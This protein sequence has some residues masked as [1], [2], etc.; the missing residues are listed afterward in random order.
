MVQIVDIHEPLKLEDYESYAFLSQA[1]HELREEAR[2]TAPLLKG[3]TVWMVNSTAQGGG[4]AEMLPKMISMLRELG[5]DVRWEV[6]GSQRPEFFVLTKRLHNLIHGAGDPE[7]SSDDRDL[8]EAV[9]RTNAQQ[10]E[11]LV[12]P[13]DL[14]VIHDPQPLGAGALV[15]EAVG[16]PAI[17]RCHIGLDD[18]TRETCAAWKFLEPWALKFDH[19]VFSAPEYIPDFLTGNAHV[20]H[21][22]ID[23]LSHKNRELSPHK[24]QGILCNS[25]LAIE[26]EPVLTPPFEFPARRLSPS[27]EWLP[28]VQAAALGLLYRP[29]IVQISRWDRLKGYGPLLEGFVRL[30]AF[31]E[32]S[33]LSDLHRRRLQILRLIL[34]GPDP[35]SVA[36]DPEGRQVIEEL[37]RQVLALPE[38][39]Q[40]DVALISLPMESRKE[41]ALMVN[42][43]QRCA[44]IVAQ[45]SIQEGFGL[46]VT[47]AMWKRT[48][49]LGSSACGIRQQIRDGIDGRLVRDPEDPEEIARALDEMLEDRMAR[50]HYASNAQRRVHAQFLIFSQLREWLRLFAGIVQRE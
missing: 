5:V 13:Q 6:I 41:N 43:L 33:D 30:K 17:W 44:T 45:N 4:V 16:L 20:I 34:G 15:K 27:G 12:E 46:T 18:R 50:D 23:P 32:R 26:H 1:V 39:I 3:R 8:Y 49:V 35:K 21:P 9:S 19:A 2:I 36:D 40:K 14:L 29:S 10:L 31:V 7:L 48:P 11:T 28:A 24:L 37:S 47:E 22:A 38:K 25:A 42:A